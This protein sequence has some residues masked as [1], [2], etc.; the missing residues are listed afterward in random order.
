VLEVGV[1]WA[2]VLG[3][4]PRGR[5]ARYAMR[6]LDAA[7]VE[8]FKA[9]LDL[10]RASS[11]VVG[12]QLASGMRFIVDGMLD[13]HDIFRPFAESWR[14]VYLDGIIR[15]FDNNFFYR[16]PV[17]R[18]EPEPQRLVLP[19]RVRALSPLAE[20]AS[21]KVVIPGPLTMTKLGRNES[22]IE[23]EELVLRVAAALAIEAREAAK[24]GADLVQVD[25]P[26]LAS[27]DAT[28]DDARLAVEAFN[29]IS[30]EVKR[31]AGTKIGIALYFDSPRGD[32]Y[33]EVLEAKADYISIDIADSPKRSLKLLSEAS[34]WDAKPVLGVIDARRIYD[35]DY[36][37]VKDYVKTAVSACKDAEEIGLTT[38]TWLDLIPLRFSLRKTVLLGLYTEMIAR[39]LG[40]EALIPISR[41]PKPYLEEGGGS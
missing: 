41:R 7:S 18:G 14:N 8:P 15:Y 3:G 36:S 26:Y 25:E 22:E 9:L 27:A 37:R 34:C 23:D 28:P 29:S 21:I 16:I 10:E 17:F 11:L 33:G 13:W 30:R 4:Y 32:V 24:A 39:E 12:A 5:L 19:G 20:P 40:L 31:E 2:A 35:D 1:L 38:S 6:D